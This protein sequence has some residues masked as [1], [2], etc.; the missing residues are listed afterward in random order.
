MPGGAA[1]VVAGAEGSATITALKAGG[2]AKV[3]ADLPQTLKDDKFFFIEDFGKT[4]VYAD[5]Q[6][7]VDV[8]ILVLL[9]GFSIFLSTKLN[10]PKL[11]DLKHI[12]FV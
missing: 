12:D 4:G 5:G 11:P 1:A 9:F 7:N 8:L 10:A 3:E 2:S 6:L